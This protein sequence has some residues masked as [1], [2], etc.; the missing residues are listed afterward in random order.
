MS[1]VRVFVLLVSVKTYIFFLSFPRSPCVHRRRLPTQLS[2]LRS[3]VLRLG[4][5]RRHCLCRVVGRQEFRISSSSSTLPLQSCWPSRSGVSFIKSR[6][7]RC[8]CSVV[9]CLAPTLPRK[10]CP[11]TFWLARSS[12]SLAIHPPSLYSSRP[13]SFGQFARQDSHPR[14]TLPDRPHYLISASSALHV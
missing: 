12:R 8:P 11:G 5:R 9:D 2:V 13:L 7:Q 4:P 6:R 14:S 3:G 10:L 1:S